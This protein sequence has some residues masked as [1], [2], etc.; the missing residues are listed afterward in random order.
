M[1]ID[2]GKDMPNFL[3]LEPSEITQIRTKIPEAKWRDLSFDRHISGDGSQFEEPITILKAIEDSLDDPLRV[4]ARNLRAL[5][6]EQITVMTKGM[7]KPDLRDT[8]VLWASAYLDGG[9]L[10]L[11]D[12]R[13]F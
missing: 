3:K 1:T 4:V 7:G 13:R 5:T 9:E 2:D 12:E 8:L 10:P 11:K 6:L